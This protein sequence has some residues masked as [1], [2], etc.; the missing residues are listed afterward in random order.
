[1]TT[2]TVKEI[3]LDKQTREIK[4]TISAKDS[5]YVQESK[6]NGF[7]TF[8]NGSPLVEGL[9]YLLEHHSHAVNAMKGNSEFKQLAAENRELKSDILCSPLANRVRQFLSAIDY[10]TLTD[11]QAKCALLLERELKPT[12]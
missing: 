11:F 1:M 7:P 3:S 6:N 2:A 8:V 10:G 9:N 4:V 5:M 12:T